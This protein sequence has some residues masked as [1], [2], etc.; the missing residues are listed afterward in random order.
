MTTRNGRLVVSIVTTVL[1]VLLP[2]VALWAIFANVVRGGDVTDFENTLYGAGQAVVD[3]ESPYPALDD[4]ALVSGKGYVY[5]P[6][7]ALVTVPLTSMSV[8]AAGFVVMALLVAGFAATLLVLGVRDWR[9][10][11]L[12]FLWPPVLSAVQTGNITIPLALGAA[13]AWRFRNDARVAGA[14][15]GLTL[16]AKPILWPLVV[17]LGVTRRLRAFVIALAVALLALAASWAVIGFA[18]LRGYPDLVRRLTD[19]EDEHGYTVYALALDL[20]A[21]SVLA[22]ALWACAAPAAL[23]GAVFL[24]RRGDDR[25]AFALCVVAALAF[26][27][28]VWQ[29][30]FAFLLV[31]VAVVQPT[32]GLAWFVPLL[33]YGSTGTL[34]GNTLQ[35]AVGLGAAVLTVAVALRPGGMRFPRARVRPARAVRLG[36]SP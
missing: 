17:W 34:N 3:G 7:T 24:A 8:E 12:A 33:M 16:A 10:Y 14:S 15:L 18:G 6:L 5:P 21:S 28:I 32:L 36:R 13:L 30:Y 29:H 27:P 11:G 23:A 9:C 1:L 35:T 20:G 25:R 22:W 31:V 2:A 19:V 4:P 26:S